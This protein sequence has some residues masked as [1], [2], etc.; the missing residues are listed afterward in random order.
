MLNNR[1]I[2]SWEEE[3]WEGNSSSFQ[4]DEVFRASSVLLSGLTTCGTREEGGRSPAVECEEEAELRHKAGESGYCF[5][6]RG[7]G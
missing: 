1:K 2:H 7:T 4:N 6:Y 3:C 5:I